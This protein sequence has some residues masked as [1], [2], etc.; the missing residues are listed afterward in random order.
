[1]KNKKLILTIG[2]IAILLVLGIVIFILTE[3]MRQEAI[4]KVEM[5][6]LSKMDVTKD[7]VDMTIKTKKEYGIVEETAKTYL[8]TY[9]NTL[10][11]IQKILNDDKIAEILTSENYKSDGPEFTESKE[12][13][14][15]MRERFNEKMNT[16]IDMTSKEM[17]M[18]AIQDKNLEEKYINLYNELML[19]DELTNDLEE[20]AKSLQE[21]N[22]LIN[23]VL[24]TQENVINMLSKNKGKW[25]INDEGQ[26]EFDTKA[27]VDEYNRYL[28]EL[29]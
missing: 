6:K 13:I 1:M 24:D 8:N 20:A 7:S 18:Q 11:D 27:L 9:S 26:I 16:L 5:S 10:K 4:L 22:E 15:S 3:D 19:G 29:N 14:T 21:S 25:E 12:Y 17:M 2:I 28:D 23:K